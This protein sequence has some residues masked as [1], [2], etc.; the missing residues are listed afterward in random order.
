MQEVNKSSEEI[1]KALSSNVR[2]VLGHLDYVARAQSGDVLGTKGDRELFELCAIFAID[3]TLAH[4][5]PPSARAFFVKL[6]NDVVGNG[7]LHDNGVLTGGM[8]GAYANLRQ[9]LIDNAERVDRAYHVLI[10]ESISFDE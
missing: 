3:T 2:T 10:E 8:H 6:I 7:Y 9:Y 5:M 4:E 1:R